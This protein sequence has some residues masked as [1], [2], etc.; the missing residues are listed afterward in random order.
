[1]KGMLNKNI[2][3]ALCR[4]GFEKL[5]NYILDIC[6]LVVEDYEKKQL[7]LPNDENKIRSIMLEEYMKRQKS[8]YGMSDYRFE[9]EVPENYAGNGRHIGRVDIRILLKNDFEKEDAFY[10]IECKRIDG[11]SDLNKKYIKEGVARFVTQKYSSYYGRNIM[12]GF[13]V[14]KID[15]SANVR[16]IEEIQNGESD[17]HMHGDF[18]FVGSKGVTESYRCMYQIHSGEMEL[19]HIFSDYS[20]IMQ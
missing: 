8:A 5:T 15:I 12:L 20:G 18:Q 13:V 11:T 1:M 3:Q 14:K 9:L 10:I 6:E 2:L 7:K 19:R 4:A 17:S 16:L